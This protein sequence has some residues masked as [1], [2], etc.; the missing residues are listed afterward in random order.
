VPLA[1]IG[2]GPAWNAP[3]AL[4]AAALLALGIGLGATIGAL[5]AR[6]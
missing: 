1:G 3:L 2:W 5:A 6:G 4:L